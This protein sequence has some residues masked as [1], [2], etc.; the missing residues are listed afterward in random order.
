LAAAAPGLDTDA[1]GGNPTYA[2]TAIDHF[3]TASAILGT[4]IGEEAGIDAND[5]GPTG[6]R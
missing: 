4:V 2:A 1:V 3:D 6:A 5:G